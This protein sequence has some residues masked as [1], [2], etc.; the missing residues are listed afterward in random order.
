MILNCGLQRAS[1][2]IAEDGGQIAQRR[3]F[4]DVWEGGSLKMY[5]AVACERQGC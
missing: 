1:D 3:G 4:G 5:I 2:L